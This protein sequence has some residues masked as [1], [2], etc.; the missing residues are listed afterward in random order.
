MDEL[1][2]SLTLAQTK[3]IKSFPIILLRFG[4]LE[5]PHRLDEDDAGGNG[6]I[7]RAA[8]HSLHRGQP[9]DHTVPHQ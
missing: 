1:F 4:V 9:E 8:L 7:D 3:R 2:E 6:T 5:G